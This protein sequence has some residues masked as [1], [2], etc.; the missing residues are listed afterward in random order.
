MIL[1]KFSLRVKGVGEDT[2]VNKKKKNIKI[3]IRSML[4]RKIK[5]SSQ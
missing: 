5:I 1:D 3:M 4:A 2:K